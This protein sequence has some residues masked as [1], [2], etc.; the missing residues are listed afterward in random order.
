MIGDSTKAQHMAQ[1]GEAMD[2]PEIPEYACRLWSDFWTL[3]DARS[4]GGFGP[5]P[6]GFQDIKAYAELTDRALGHNDVAA[7]RLLDD[8]FIEAVAKL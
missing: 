5:N 6:I 3:S 1:A 4:S 2:I 8:A 7:I